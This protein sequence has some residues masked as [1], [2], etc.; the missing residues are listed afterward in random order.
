MVLDPPIVILPLMVIVKVVTASAR[1]I[2]TGSGL[3]AKTLIAV[4]DVAPITTTTYH[5]VVTMM[6]LLVEGL[7]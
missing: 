2:S 4:V 3:T 1:S 7:L 5:D 6:L